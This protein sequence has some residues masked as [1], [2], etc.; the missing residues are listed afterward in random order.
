MPSDGEQSC[1][2]PNMSVSAGRLRIVVIQD[3]CTTISP[4]VIADQLSSDGERGG[5]EYANEF[6]EMPADFDEWGGP[7][8]GLEAS[9]G[10]GYY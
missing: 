6:C 5:D 10:G 2:P 3:L 8:Y 7:G 4:N 1:T 9:G